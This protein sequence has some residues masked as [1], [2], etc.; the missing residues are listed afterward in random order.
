MRH[1][2][3][4]CIGLDSFQQAAEVALVS[5][6]L[7]R[8]ATEIYNGYSCPSGGT[9]RRRGLKILRTP[10]LE[11]SSPFSGTNFSSVFPENV[12]VSCSA[13]YVRDGRFAGQLRAYTR[14][15]I[16]CACGCSP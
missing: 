9:G 11:G 3:A 5:Q 7:E 15:G 2:L 14:Q 13:T 1:A 12:L 10:V 4:E 6:H 8:K 16:D